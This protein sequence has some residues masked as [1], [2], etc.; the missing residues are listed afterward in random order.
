MQVLV[1]GA[2]GFVGAALIDRLRGSGYFQIRAA[3]RRNGN[4]MAPGV[5]TVCVGDIGADTLWG[6]VLTDVHTVVHLAARVH[7][8]TADASDP[9]A[10]FRRTNVA[11]TLNLAR[12]AAAGGVRRF[13]FLSSIKVNGESTPPGRRFTA[14]D[15]PAPVD[16]YGISKLEAEVG[17][18]RLAGTKME[19]VIIR[20]PLVYGPHVKGNFLRLLSWIERGMP[21]PFANVDNRRSLVS[22]HNLA[23]LIEQC[24]TH[25]AAGGQTFLISDGAD[26]STGDLV[27]RLAVVMGK[28][29]RLFP[30]PLSLTRSALRRFGKEDLCQRVF[31]SLQVNGQT[32]NDFLGWTPPVTMAAGLEEVGRWYLRTKEVR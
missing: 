19:I 28:R 25:P 31:G 20:P 7:V 6:P 27:R 9:L 23:A 10:E 1:T 15:V 22:V 32:T 24:I 8:M 2:T 3:L 14:A 17:L 5:E 29:P 13:I 21:L 16:P 30:V 18:R 12:Q 4:P 11:G 26:I